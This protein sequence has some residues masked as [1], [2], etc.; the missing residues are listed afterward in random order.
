MHACVLG[1]IAF[2]VWMEPVQLESQQGECPRPHL[3]GM[4]QENAAA[5]FVKLTKDDMEYLEDIF[6]GKVRL[7]R[8]PNVVLKIQRLAP[9]SACMWCLHRWWVSGMA[10]M[11]P[12]IRTM[13]TRQPEGWPCGVAA[14]QPSILECSVHCV[15]EV[16]MRKCPATRLRALSPKIRLRTQCHIAECKVA[17]SPM[18]PVRACLP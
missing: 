14:H 1:C 9:A 3:G 6:H 12:S 17:A 5:F 13:R 7:L 16:C 2:P 11:Q 4:L 15:Q 18:P 10:A 8:H